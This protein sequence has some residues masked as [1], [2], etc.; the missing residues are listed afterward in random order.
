[1][2]IHLPKKLPVFLLLLFF[3]LFQPELGQ[4]HENQISL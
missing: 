2:S 3:V 1:M 4:I